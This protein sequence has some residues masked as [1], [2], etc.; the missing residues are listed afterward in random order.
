MCA[1]PGRTLFTLA[2]EI[3]ERV[4]DADGQADEQQ[5]GA[6]VR[7]H[8]DEVAGES[9][10]ADR[11]GDGGEREEE[12][13]ACGDDRAEDDEQDEQR[14]RNRPLA[15]L[16]ELL[17]ERVVQRL[18]GA[19]RAGLPD[20]EARMR[21]LHA[22]C[23]LRERVDALRREVVVTLHVPL[24][25]RRVAVGRDLVGTARVVGRPEV[26]DRRERGDR[27]DDI[28]DDGAELRRVRGER[29]ALN[30]HDLGLRIGLEAGVAQDVVRA[31]RLA[32]VRVLLV[33]LLRTDLHADR[34]GCDH[35]REPAEDRGLPVACAPA[36]HACCEVVRFGQG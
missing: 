1:L 22:G 25:H 3:E 21:L 23:R 24:D 5:D 20:V 9:D 27:A 7:V 16:R 17:V 33:D 13:H 8:R 30:E 26:L 14:E 6:D 34:E 35:E 36:T 29:L 2:L 4:V 19:D 18:A 28:A 10:E 11:P 32:D 15:G 12:R 31:M